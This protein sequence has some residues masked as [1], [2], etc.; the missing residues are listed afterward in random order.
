MTEPFQLAEYDST[1]TCEACGQRG[2]GAAF[3]ISCADAKLGCIWTCEACA[4]MHPH[5]LLTAAFA[6]ARENVPLVNVFGWHNEVQMKRSLPLV[7]QAAGIGTL[8]A[9]DTDWCECCLE[10][11]VAKPYS[12]A[13]FGVQ[14]SKMRL[15]RKCLRLVTKWKKP[16]AA[17]AAALWT[18]RNGR[19]LPQLAE[20]REKGL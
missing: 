3:D 9:D 7:A 14:L 12:M 18:L 1:W 6:L 17:I 5:A 11:N 4:K 19:V 20:W 8:V 13:C 15:C 16:Q 2:V 10:R